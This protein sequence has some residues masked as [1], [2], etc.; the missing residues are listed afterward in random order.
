MKV[1]V[2]V[3]A[4]FALAA[5]LVVAARYNEG[6]VLVVLPPYRVEIALS[7][8][9]I[10][11]VAGFLVLYSA[12]RLVS[13][14]VQVPAKVRQYRLARR[15]D[16]AQETLLL[17]LESYFEGR[18]SRA[19]Q[20]AAR[21]IALGEHK[22]LSAVIAAR[23][24]HELRAFDRRDRYLR[25]L[26]EGAP[27][28]NPL[29]AVTEAELLLD[30]RRPNDALGVLQALP[31]KHT[32]A[33][34]LELKAQQQTRQWEPV[35]GLVGELERRGV[36]DVEQAGQLRAHAVLENLRRP[37][38]DAQSL[39]ETWKRLSEPQKRDGA[40]AAAAAQSHMKLGRG[41]DAQRIVEQ[42][43]TQKWNSELV[44]LY[45]DVDGD[46]VKQIELAEEWLVLHPGDAA[47]LL[48]LGKL[49]ARQALW[50]KAQSYLEA[51]IAVQPTYAAHLELAQLH[52]RLGNPDGA[53]RHYRASLECAL[54]I[55]DGGGARLRLGPGRPT[56]QRDTNGF[57]P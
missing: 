22:R 2:W 30:D 13:G 20:A 27:E 8:L 45:G 56:E 53:R 51:S 40:I 12:V 43:L 17:A 6:Y 54:E 42:S 35:V 49:C 55:L 24:A 26:A 3:V 14:A 10:L 18:Y 52:E 39:D 21:S 1:L 32:A 44:A 7:L 46:A 31:Q 11:F 29:R 48:T 36:F 23:A 4:L 33:L 16:K 47:L 37:G 34:R 15:R 5:G 19:E 41:A 57:P 25:E 38:L 50:G 9:L 28:E